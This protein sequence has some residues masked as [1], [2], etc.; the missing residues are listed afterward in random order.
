MD[1]F[2][3]AQISEGLFC[4][5]RR[6]RSCAYRLF[7]H[8]VWEPRFRS[9]VLVEQLAALL[10]ETI[11]AVCERYH[12]EFLGLCVVDDH[13]HLHL[14]LPPRIA[15][16]DAIRTIKSL[17]ARRLLEAFPELRDHLGGGAFWADGYSVDSVGW[18]NPAQ[19]CAYLSRQGDHHDAP[20]IMLLV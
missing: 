20:T 1:E 2:I 5:V 18:S 15:P 19:L 14:G 3:R 10:A 17:T 13:V 8:F 11:V 9:P 6:S 7:Y 12:Y 16:S 4:W